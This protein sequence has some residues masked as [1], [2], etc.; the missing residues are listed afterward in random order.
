MDHG[1]VLQPVD[2]VDAGTVNVDVL[3]PVNQSVGHLSSPIHPSTPSPGTRGRKSYNIML[4]CQDTCN[5][6]L[7]FSRQYREF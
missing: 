7:S 3:D 4:A 1:S 6:L 2:L 5:K